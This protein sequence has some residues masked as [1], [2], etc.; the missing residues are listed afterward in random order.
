MGIWMI[1]YPIAVT[2]GLSIGRLM[3]MEGWRPLWT[4][5]CGHTTDWGLNTR[6]MCPK[7]GERDHEWSERV[8]RDR[9]PFGYEFKP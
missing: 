3:T 6:K 5:N 2:L 9:F 4:H 7:C 1:M 8:G